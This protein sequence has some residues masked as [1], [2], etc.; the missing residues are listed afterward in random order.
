MA[1]AAVMPRDSP[2]LRNL[3]TACAAVTDGCRDDVGNAI[4]GAARLME[5][6]R[7]AA[8]ASFLA[9]MAIID[10]LSTVRGGWALLTLSFF[11]A[12]AAARLGAVGRLTRLGR[13]DGMGCWRRMGFGRRV[14][15]CGR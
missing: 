1:C 10:L 4:Y 3:V 15:P 11:G 2:L 7:L 9:R 14:L 6:F 12:L 13:R 5:A 8:A